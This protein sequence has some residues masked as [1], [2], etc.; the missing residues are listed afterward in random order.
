MAVIIVMNGHMDALYGKY[1]YLATGGSIGD[2][3]FFFVS[4]FTIFLGRFGRF[5]NW[6]KRRIKRVYPSVIAWATVLSFSAF[7]QLTM[8]QIVCGGGYWFISCIMLYYVVLWFV[9]CYAEHKPLIPF[10]LCCVSIVV[11][12]CFMDSANMAMYGDNYFKWLFFF[13]F[14]LFGAYVGNGTLKMMPRPRIDGI[15]LALSILLFYGFQFV[16]GKYNNM[17]W[18]NF[19]SLVPL[20]GVTLFGYKLCCANGATRMMQTKLGWCIRLIAGL[21]LEVYIVQ[22][23]LIPLLSKSIGSLFP[24]SILVTFVVVI[25]VAYLTRCI[26]RV[27]SQIFEKED[28]DWKKVFEFVG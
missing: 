8:A 6:Y 25:V 22:V 20:V 17:A 4:G 10:L 3:L 1:S 5:D 13:L 9:R 16:S 24:L 12:Y 18:L 14:M 21:C 7:E 26:G 15:M 28:M 23:T 27:I 19:L 2:A 11:G